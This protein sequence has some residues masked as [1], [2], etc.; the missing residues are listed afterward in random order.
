MDFGKKTSQV[1][2]LPFE[3]TISSINVNVDGRIIVGLLTAKTKARQKSGSLVIISPDKNLWGYTILTGHE[4]NTEDCLIMGPRI[5]TC[6]ID[7]RAEHTIRFWGTGSYVKL[8][9]SKLSIEPS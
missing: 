6:G 7:S 8:A 4:I 1:I 3:N 2:A 5:I 9:V